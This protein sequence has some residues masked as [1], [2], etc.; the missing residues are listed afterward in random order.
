MWY[1]FYK[2]CASIQ[3]TQIFC[4]LHILVDKKKK[5]SDKTIKEVQVGP[6]LP[7]EGPFK[8]SAVSMNRGYVGLSVV[9]SCFYRL[10]TLISIL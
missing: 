6:S 4:P 10:S 7:K 5:G 9:D 2:K 8:S 1:H 3:N